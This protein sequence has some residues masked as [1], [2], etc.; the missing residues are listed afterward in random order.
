MNWRTTETKDKALTVGHR[1]TG[2]GEHYRKD[3][4]VVAHS[5]HELPASPSRGR[6][7]RGYYETVIERLDL[8]SVPLP[9][10]LPEEHLALFC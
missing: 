8:I 3:I 4:V 7:R 1:L 6:A 10:I 2:S 5:G 9:L